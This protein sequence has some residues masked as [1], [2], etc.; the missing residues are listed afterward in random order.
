MHIHAKRLLTELG[1]IDNAVVVIENGRFSEVRR[2]TLEDSI[3]K[4][5]KVDMLLPALID[6]HV[7]GG[8]GVDVM[9]ATH[10]ALNKLSVHLASRGVGAFLATTVTATPAAID[11]ALNNVAHSM[12]RGVDGATI[13]GSYLEGPY[14]TEK[15]KGAHD[16]DLFREL[17][18]A[19]LDH[20]IEVSEGT[21][22][23]VALAPEKE[24]ACQAITHLKA[25]G[26]NVMLAHTEAS[27]EQTIAAFDAGADGIVHCFNGMTGLHHREPGVVGAGLSDER[28]YV[29][30][31]ADG[32]H[33]HPAAMKIC[34]TCAQ[35]RLVL[36]SDAMR[37][38]GMPDGDYRL[39]ELT[40]KMEQ[41]VVRTETGGLA[42]STLALFKG[43]KNMHTLVGL[44]LEDAV[45]RASLTPARMLG[46][47]E[48]YGSIALGKLANFI[49][50]NDQMELTETWVEGSQVWST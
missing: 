32:H 20:L 46:I 8:G 28:A 29:E 17:V 14:F 41:G 22:K 50:V 44:S 30:L 27:Y 12:K 3:L 4:M 21:L 23:A 18:P 39:G 11:H 26:V 33:V 36:I 38:A 43:V 2:Y 10:E 31:I 47:E 37:A 48:N 25:R 13:L 42:G 16:A 15:Y 34:A 6:T 5:R 40:V 9:D 19:E 7:H 45:N 49:I 35:E 1:W 24:N